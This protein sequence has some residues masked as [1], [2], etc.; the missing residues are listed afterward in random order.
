MVALLAGCRRLAV[1][2]KGKAR[3][4]EKHG[5]GLGTR[6]SE[7]RGGWL[8]CPSAGAYDDTKK[9]RSQ[10]EADVSSGSQESW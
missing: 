7:A 9:T 4:R 6:A 8:S 1:G 2:A 5:T 3:S 10:R